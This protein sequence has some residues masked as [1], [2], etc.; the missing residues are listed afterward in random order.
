[1]HIVHVCAP[2]LLH[3]APLYALLTKSWSAWSVFFAASDC[4][5]K[6]DKLFKWFNRF[7]GLVE[8]S[9]KCSLERGEQ[10]VMKVH[11]VDC[12]NLHIFACFIMRPAYTHA[13][14]LIHKLHSFSMT[15]R[16]GIEGRNNERTVGNRAEKRVML[17]YRYVVFLIFDISNTH[18]RAQHTLI[19]AIFQGLSI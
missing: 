2:S 6:F 14:T 5:I 10:G 8:E 18:T 1:M 4:G 7:S 17:Y 11:R 15:G 19:I 9:G 16:T 13:H 3:T 12:G